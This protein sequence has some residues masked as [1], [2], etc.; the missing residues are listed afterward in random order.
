[1]K[2]LIEHA[3]EL[4]EYTQ[5]LRRDFH[6]HPELGFQEVRTAGIVASE[7]RALGL[8]TTTGVAQ[9]G[10]VALIEGHA[11][12]PVVLLRFDM[13]ALPIMEE[14]GAEYCSEN[15]G[16]MHACGHDGHTAIG[17]TVAKLLHAC[18]SEWVGTIKLVF[19][20][21]EEGC[22]G[23]E[24]MVKEG[25]LEDPRPDYSLALHLWNEMP[26]GMLGITSGPV[27]AAAESFDVTITGKGAHGALPHEGVD[28]ILAASQIVSALQSVVSRNVSPLETGVISITAL[29][30]GT[31]HNV[32]PQTVDLKGTIRS[33]K[34]EISELIIERFMKIVNGVAESF[35]CTAEVKFIDNAPAVVNNE[36]VTCAVNITAEKM[37]PGDQILSNLRTTGAEDMSFIMNEIPGCYFFVGSSDPQKGLVYGHHHP[38]FDFNELA[39]S[40]A[41]GLMAGA[42]LE[43]LK[44]AKK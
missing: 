39:M 2:N 25:V 28:P 19:Q 21:G 41:A 20:P 36:D 4:F 33:Y 26:M 18:Q 9:T 29:R 17:L 38:K 1:M 14:T 16:V 40:K 13:D 11:P 35:G 37:F 43:V 3:E 15:A 10:V 22:G 42:A 23:A 12:G 31:T 32:I 6:R 7:L 8:E 24:T 44:L 5:S 34:P 27:M 30:G